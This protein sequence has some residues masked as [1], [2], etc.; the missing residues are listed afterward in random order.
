MLRVMCGFNLAKNLAWC[1]RGTAAKPHRNVEQTGADFSVS[2][3]HHG[4]DTSNSYL[5]ILLCLISLINITICIYI[6]TCIYLCNIY[7]YI[8]IHIHMYVLYIYIYMYIHTCIYLCNIYIYIHIHIHMYVLYICIYNTYMHPYVYLY[9]LLLPY[10]L[11][12]CAELAELSTFHSPGW[13]TSAMSPRPKLLEERCSVP[14]RG[15]NW[16]PV[17]SFR[18]AG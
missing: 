9:L 16:R 6:Y 17:T 8:H 14:W 15:E 4:I 5:C 2:L 10:L 7:T 1:S 13:L 11:L 18:M 3:R 12:R